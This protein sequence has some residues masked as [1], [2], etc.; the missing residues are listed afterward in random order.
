MAQLRSATAAMTRLAEQARTTH[1][2]F[3]AAVADARVLLERSRGNLNAAQTDWDTEVDLARSRLESLRAARGTTSGENLGELA[4]RVASLRSLVETL[5]NQGE[6]SLSSI[7]SRASELQELLSTRLSSAEAAMSEVNDATGLLLTETEERAG[8]VEERLSSWASTVKANSETLAQ[9]VDS[10]TEHFRGRSEN[11]SDHLDGSVNTSSS[12]IES[13]FLTQAI[14]S[15][16][17]AASGVRAATSLLGNAKEE[18]VGEFEDSLA[19]LIGKI[20]PIL[21]VIETIK[22]ILEMAKAIL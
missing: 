12:K 7:S 13:S 21:D 8:T 9:A 19:G 2:A 6:D 14:Q 4:P 18:G 10:L 15:L 17:T 5:E 1:H 20:R 3:C 11:F 16:E 22:P